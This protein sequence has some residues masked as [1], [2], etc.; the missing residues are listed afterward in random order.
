M[1]FGD[2]EITTDS[3]ELFYKLRAL[4][5]YKTD[6]YAEI[7]PYIT[8]I[9]FKKAIHKADDALL[10]ELNVMKFG[11]RLNKF[12]YMTREKIIER[13]SEIEDKETLA[14]AL[15]LRETEGLFDSLCFLL[16]IGKYAARP[17]KR[18]KPR[19]KGAPRNI[20]EKLPPPPDIESM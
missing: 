5:G 7:S 3:H 4:G 11:I 12:N 18:Y 6:Y 17:R 16:K 8:H 15:H 20:N 14:Y 10:D 13:I 19:K 9:G 1:L 2:L